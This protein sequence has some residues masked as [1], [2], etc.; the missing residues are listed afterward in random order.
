M[1]IIKNVIPKEVTLFGK[2]KEH[3][4]LV[5]DADQGPVEAIAFF[6][7]PTDFAVEPKVGGSL[8]LVAHL[9]QSFFM[10]RQQT[11]L[12]VVECVKEIS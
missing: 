7:L 3:T 6:K 11:R 5:F 2:T 1:V 4:K 9:E 10:G 12:R 8:C